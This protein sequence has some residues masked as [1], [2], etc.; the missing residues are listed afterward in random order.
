MQNLMSSLLKTCQKTTE[1]I[2]KQML[3]PLTLTEKA[4]L[5]AHKAMCKTCNAY[6]KQSK[7]ID[8]LLGKWFGSANAK[9]QV[10]MDAEKKDS[11]IDQ[12][13]KQ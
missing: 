8:S 1:L 10:K 4:Q 6:A 3:T 9:A 7:I 13:D 11:I 2:D 12:L 5:K